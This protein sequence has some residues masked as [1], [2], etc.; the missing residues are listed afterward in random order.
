M[1]DF[2]GRYRSP[3]LV[4]SVVLVAFS[5]WSEKRQGETE[6]E[7]LGKLEEELEEAEREVE[8]E[9]AETDGASARASDRDASEFERDRV[10]SATSG[11]RDMR[12]RRW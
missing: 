4:L 2:I 6:V 3:L 10:G 5:I 1:L 8:A 12:E 9:R 11:R 7:S